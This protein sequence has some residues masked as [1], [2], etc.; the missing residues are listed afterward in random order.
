VTSGISRWRL[1]DDAWAELKKSG[2]LF[3]W[4]LLHSVPKHD[5]RCDQ[6]QTP[7]PE[8]LL[9]NAT[10]PNFTQSIEEHGPG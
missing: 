2:S 1:I 5:S 9:L 7:G 10:I 4:L 6:V 3:S 8:A